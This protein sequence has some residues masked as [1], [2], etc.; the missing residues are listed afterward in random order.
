MSQP[1]QI[2]VIRDGLFTSRSLTADIN[3]TVTTA[4][5]LVKEHFGRRPLTAVE[6]VVTSPKKIP[7]LAA[8]AQGAAAG[9]P[10][11]VYAEKLLSFTAKPHDL[12]SVT[13]IAPKNTI[14]VLINAKRLRRRPREIGATLV[15][16]FV[17]VDQL[18]RKGSLERRIALTRHEMGT[19]VL[20]KGKV[21]SLY[22]VEAEMEAQAEKA[23]GQ[24]VGKVI[25]QNRQAEAAAAREDTAAANR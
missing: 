5:R 11:K 18:C 8:T 22:R 19:H 25:R 21:R 15:W 23:T 20:S 10:E 12:Y 6:V 13:V 7:A 4:Q 2:T 24:I 3:D 9:I 16:A 17:E 14:R 1:T